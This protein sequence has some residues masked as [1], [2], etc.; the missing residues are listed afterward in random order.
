MVQVKRWTDYQSVLQGGTDLQSGLRC[1]GLTIHRLPE[2]PVLAHDLLF[3]FRGRARRP[4]DLARGIRGENNID[5]P[6]RALVLREEVIQLVPVHFLVLNE[7][8]ASL[9]SF[10]A[11]DLDGQAVLEQFAL[12][13]GG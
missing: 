3:Q 2:Q 9:R 13:A 4:F 8:E 12:A 11:E 1:R 10:A 7:I 5:L 6:P